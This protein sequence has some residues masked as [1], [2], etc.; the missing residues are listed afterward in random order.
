[1]LETIRAFA[2][3][4]LRHRAESDQ[5]YARHA[6]YFVDLAEAADRELHRPAQQAS[7]T[8][9][10]SNISNL[11]AAL[12]WSLRH[13]SE[14][15]GRLT[16]ATAQFWFIDGGWSEGEERADAVLARGGLSQSVHERALFCSALLSVALQREAA[17]QRA[18]DLL[19][20]AKETG[21]LWGMGRA[22]MLLGWQAGLSG[23]HE[24][25]NDLGTAGSRASLRTTSP[26]SLWIRAGMTKPGAFS[27]KAW[28]LLAL[29]PTTTW[30]R[31]RLLTSD[32]LRSD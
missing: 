29:E 30:R 10:K 17:Q 6:G 21:S 5:V 28:R 3:D 7:L 26:T 19:R 11:R 9:F 8:A 31:G 24:R 4:R 12:S 1:M 20:T 16:G 14:A 13:D 18:E 22:L 27:R 25:A 2:V 32:R 23:E 15:A